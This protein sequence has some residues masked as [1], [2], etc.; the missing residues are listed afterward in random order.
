MEKVDSMSAKW[1]K[2]DTVEKSVESFNLKLKETDTRVRKVESS[3]YD[4]IKRVE[5]I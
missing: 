4:T 2:L 3:V 5:Y 1:T